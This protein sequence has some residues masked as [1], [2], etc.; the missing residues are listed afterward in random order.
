M[1]RVR[2]VAKAGRAV[3]FVLVE[4]GCPGLGPLFPR[5]FQAVGAVSLAEV[6]V[7]PA[8]GQS[9]PEGY[10]HVA[11][12][13]ELVPA[14]ALAKLGPWPTVQTL[15]ERFGHSLGNR[16]LSEV[17][18]GRYHVQA[19]GVGGALSL[20]AVAVVGGEAVGASLR[21]QA[22]VA[23]DTMGRVHTTSVGA[24][25]EP[26]R[27]VVSYGKA[28][29]PVGGS[30]GWTERQNSERIGSLARGVLADG[31]VSGL[32]N[33]VMVWPEEDTYV[34]GTTVSDVVGGGVD[35]YPVRA[36]IDGLSKVRLE[37]EAGSVIVFPR[38]CALVGAS[39]ELGQV[40]GRVYAVAVASGT[41]TF[42]MRME[43]PTA[44]YVYQPDATSFTAMHR[45][46]YAFICGFTRMEL[47]G[48]AFGLL[49]QVGKPTRVREGELPDL[50]KYTMVSSGVG[51][52]LGPVR[53]KGVAGA[54]VIVPR[55]VLGTSV[56]HGEARVEAVGEDCYKPGALPDPA[57]DVSDTSSE[58]EYVVGSG[59]PT[60]DEGFDPQAQTREVYPCYG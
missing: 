11:M 44:V 36:Q 14:V 58:G 10:C 12:A 25:D 45:T 13:S 50:V 31:G 38:R 54:S 18:P 22:T 21:R 42:H 53:L 17:A 24:D 16:G 46:I 1:E 59:Y 55:H 56:G 15:E 23:G 7:V 2:V 5:Y 6:L 33:V 26:G 34:P 40:S 8:D 32:A 39:V 41:F 48:A 60:C 4:D 30:D 28:A 49:G 52:E 29:C 27:P 20:P 43:K 19:D 35:Y 37:A 57:D 3:A 51:L 47:S 9:Y